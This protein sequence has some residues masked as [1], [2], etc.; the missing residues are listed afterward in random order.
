MGDSRISGFWKWLLILLVVCN[1]GLIITVWVKPQQ[2]PAEKWQAMGREHRGG[3]DGPRRG[4]IT[5]DKELDLTDDQRNK[6]DDMR[7]RH[8]QR[9]DSI[10]R[11]AGATR[12]EFFDNLNAVNPDSARYMALDV[13]LGDYHRQIELMTFNHFRDLRALLNEQQKALFDKYIKT[14]LRRMPEQPHTRD[15]GP[16]P[17]GCGP[18]G[19]P[20]PPRDGEPGGREHGDDDR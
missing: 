7:I 13:R 5:F 11:L 16:P 12:E 14:A 20:C 15:D 8:Q 17:P 1:L 6:F 19:P 18:D 4:P 10:K 2:P 9:I 3:H